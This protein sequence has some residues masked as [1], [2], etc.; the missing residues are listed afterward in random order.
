MARLY[1]LGE[2]FLELVEGIEQL[3]HDEV[4]QGPQL[5]HGILNRSTCE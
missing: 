4:Q 5:S 2:P 1:V 3:G